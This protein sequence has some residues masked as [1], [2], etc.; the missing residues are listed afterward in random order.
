MKTV[1]EDR[2]ALVTGSGK[3]VGAGIVRVLC[4]AGFRCLI[5]CNSNRSMAEETLASI[6]AQGGEAFIYQADVSDPA[7][8]RAMV[9]AA[10]PRYGRLDML[11]NNAAMQYNLFVDE[12]TEETLR[13]LWDINLG[14]YWRMIKYALPYLRRSPC[15]RIINIGSVHGKRPTCFDAGYAMTKGGI[16]MLTREAALELQKDHI[17]VN[18]ISLG[19]CKIEFKTGHPAFHNYRPQEV[20]NPDMA[21]GPRLVMPEEVGHAVLFLTTPAAAALNGDCIRIDGAQ[22]LT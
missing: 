9:E 21:S 16:K 2:V 13:R 14:G 4:Q 19:G 3:G 5:N 6:Q 17:P 18:C 11:V 8:A 10:V 22:L 12:Y 7:Q 15:P 20:R 1:T